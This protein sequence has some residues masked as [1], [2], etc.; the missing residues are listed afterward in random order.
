MVQL[1]KHHVNFSHFFGM[2]IFNLTTFITFE[3]YLCSCF[4]SFALFLF[5]LFIFVFVFH[6][7]GIFYISTWKRITFILSGPR[8]PFHNIKASCYFRW[9]NSSLHC[10]R[11]STECEHIAV[12][13]E[14]HC[15]RCVC[16][17]RSIRLV[18]LSVCAS[19]CM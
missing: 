15:V 17:A 18:Y 7:H 12:F 10:A 4:S 16:V 2:Q 14:S 8:F 13:P 5:V 1:S 6:S 3:H 11:P 19:V 9:N